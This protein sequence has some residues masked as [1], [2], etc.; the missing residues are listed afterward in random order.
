MH[1][2]VNSA[3][4]LVHANNLLKVLLGE[5]QHL[6]DVQTKEII[7]AVRVIQESH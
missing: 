4:E 7:P 5:L 1:D 3:D 6:Q 2:G